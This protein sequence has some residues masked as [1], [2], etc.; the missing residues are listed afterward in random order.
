MLYV[1]SS[2]WL[3]R[4]VD[5]PDSVVCEGHMLADPRWVT[6]RHA[7][8]EVRRNLKRLLPPPAL[9]VARADFAADWQRSFVV[10]LDEATCERAAEIAEETGARSLDALHL[11]AASRLGSGLRLLTYDIRQGSAARLLGMIVVG[12]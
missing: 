1:D 4:Y 9:G 2:A 3:K 12:V 8:V 11:A 10:E 6:S 7:L 5:E